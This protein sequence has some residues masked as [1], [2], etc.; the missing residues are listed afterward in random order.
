MD[1]VILAIF[2]I[3]GFIVG[4]AFG[5]F[6]FDRWRTRTLG[7]HVSEIKDAEKSLKRFK[8]WEAADNAASERRETEE[9]SD[10]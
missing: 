7:K 4:F 10:K 1:L 6:V 3:S 8:E 5:W 2:A 9:S